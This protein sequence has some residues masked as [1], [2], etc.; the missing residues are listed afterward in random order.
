MVNELSGYMNYN[1]TENIFSGHY[2]SEKWH[3]KQIAMLELIREKEMSE[4]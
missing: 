3:F 2:V 4:V 1:L